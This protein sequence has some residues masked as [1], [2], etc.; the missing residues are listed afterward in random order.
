MQNPSQDPIPPQVIQ[1]SQIAWLGAVE[2]ARQQAL[3]RFGG[4][5]VGRGTSEARPERRTGDR[6]QG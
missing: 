2:I 6:R 5:V 1:P 4:T 3:L